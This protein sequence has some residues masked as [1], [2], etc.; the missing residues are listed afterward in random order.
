MGWSTNLF[1][2]IEFN[3]QTYNTRNEVLDRIEEVKQC[4]K[5]TEDYLRSLVLITEPNKFCTEDCDPLNWLNV[6]FQENI[7]LYEE[8]IIELY[9]LD[10]LLNNWDACHN[11][12]GLAIN[13]PK[14]VNYGS[15]FLNGDFIKNE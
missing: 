7:K 6:E 5:T 3:R 8:Y 4:L 9:K 12:E 13:T 15:A 11:K 2:N 10:L 1:C 14:G